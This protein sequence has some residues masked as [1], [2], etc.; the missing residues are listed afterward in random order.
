MP[1]IRGR[2]GPAG[3]EILLNDVKSVHLQV[4]SA[5]LLV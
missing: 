1:H 4:S 5:F 2:Y 3:G